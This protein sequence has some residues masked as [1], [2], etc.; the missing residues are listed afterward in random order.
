MESKKIL[1][2]VS[3]T[4]AGKIYINEY[5]RATLGM[6]TGYKEHKVRVL[7]TGDSVLFSLMPVDV[8]Y[9]GKLMKTLV[10]LNADL[11]LDK[12]SLDERNIDCSLAEESFKICDRDAILKLVKDSH[13]TISL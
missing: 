3:E 13:F 8:G 5:L 1:V 9:T 11:Y 2:I 12:K 10:Y 7:F 6:S 4:P